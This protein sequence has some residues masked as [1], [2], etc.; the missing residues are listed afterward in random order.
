MSEENV[1]AVRA[2]VAA[3]NAGDA[4]A[5][6]A[7][8]DPGIDYLP[9]LAAL[10]G[11]HGAYSGHPGLRQYVRDLAEAWDWYHVEIDDLHDLGDHVLMEGRLQA[12]GKS[13]GL[14][15]EEEMAWLH[16]FREGSGPGRYVRLRF[17]PSREQALEA[18]GLS[19]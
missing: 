7:L 8:A 6:I 9:Y 16:S 4:D 12:R 5:L 11:E 15:V 13:S 14:D 18:A 19:E 17:F 1:D 10:S 3:I 2:W